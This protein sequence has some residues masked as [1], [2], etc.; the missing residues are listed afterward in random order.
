MEKQI[1]RVLLIGVCFLV[2]AFAIGFISIMLYEDDDPPTV[3]RY[4]LDGTAVAIFWPLFMGVIFIPGF[5]E[6][7][8][9]PAF[10]VLIAILFW[11]MFFEG[12]RKV[13][14]RRWKTPYS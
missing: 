9:G 1:V 14:K 13:L 5:I 11:G 3:L 7:G 4:I 12:A 8:F 10:A 2:F 6:S